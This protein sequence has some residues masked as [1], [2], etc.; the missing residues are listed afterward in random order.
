MIVKKKFFSDSKLKY[1][2]YAWLCRAQ[3]I[4]DKVLDEIYAYI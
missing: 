2:S 4:W 3:L 1:N